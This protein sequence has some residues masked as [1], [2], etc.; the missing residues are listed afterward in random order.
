[1]A[2]V[3][4]EAE[5]AAGRCLGCGKNREDSVG[6]G[7][8]GARGATRC[9]RGRVRSPEM[10]NRR[11][12]RRRERPGRS[13]SQNASAAGR[14]CHFGARAIPTRWWRGVCWRCRSRRG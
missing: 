11:R 7:G 13:R 1:L 9:A 14:R 12:G 4:D 3:C 8:A 10:K 2:R 6:A 5:A